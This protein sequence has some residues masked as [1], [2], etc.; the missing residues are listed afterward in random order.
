MNLNF[1]YSFKF[2]LPVYIISAIIGGYA[3]AIVGGIGKDIQY[4][5]DLDNH[6]LSILLGLV[7]LG[8][9]LAKVVW[10]ATDRIG[11]RAMIISFAIM[12]IIGTYLL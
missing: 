10:L 6:Q 4:N 1:R 8:G 3:L 11:R 5:F 9:I 7:F 12:Y 2:I